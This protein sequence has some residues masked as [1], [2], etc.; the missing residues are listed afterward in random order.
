[1][2][3]FW[4][5]AA[6]PLIALTSYAAYA[7]LH[8]PITET[9]AT[10][11]AALTEWVDDRRAAREAELARITQERAESERSQAQVAAEAARQEAE[12]RQEAERAAQA[13][14][15]AERQATN[16]A[17]TARAQAEQ[18]R[19]DAEAALRERDAARAEADALRAQLPATNTNPADTTTEIPGSNP[20]TFEPNAARTDPMSTYLFDPLRTSTIARMHVI[21]PA[22]S[23]IAQRFSTTAESVYATLIVE[24]SLDPRAHNAP[25]AKHGL[26]QVRSIV[27][28]NIGRT[29]SYAP[30]EN[31]ESYEKALEWIAQETGITDF[32]TLAAIHSRTGPLVTLEGYLASHELEHYRSL[33]DRRRSLA[34]E[35]IDACE[36][37]LDP[38]LEAI[39]AIEGTMSERYY[40]LARVSLERA[41][42]TSGTRSSVHLENAR[43]AIDAYILDGGSDPALRT[44]IDQTYNEHMK[45]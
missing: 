20:V 27:L 28:E 10:A 26:A 22:V 29:A 25:D 17:E 40:A 30:S 15:E 8:D 39:C 4:R 33:V 44:R 13:R 36:G 42:L 23:R 1:M 2:R 11:Q 7:Y 35:L 3:R 5:E 12:S 32:V 45:P 24:S 31:L 38:D 37:T 6:I 9:Y 43:L 34:S 19:R 21:E 14:A 41:S 16:D 18:A